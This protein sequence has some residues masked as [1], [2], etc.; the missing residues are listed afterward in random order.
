M[1]AGSDDQSPGIYSARLRVGLVGGLALSLGLVVVP[2]VK[3]RPVCMGMLHGLVIMSVGMNPGRTS[4]DMLMI[5]MP[6]VVTMPM[7]MHKGFVLVWVGM[8]LGEQQQQGE[9]DQPGG[10]GL[11]RSERLTQD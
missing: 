1:T 9:Y 6:V 11:S 7:M 3:I 2:M 10:T 5:M 4:T 8:L